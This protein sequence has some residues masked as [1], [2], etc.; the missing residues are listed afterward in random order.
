[1]KGGLFCKNVFMLVVGWFLVFLWTGW[2]PVNQITWLL[3]TA[4]VLPGMIA[5]LCSY[6]SFVFSTPTCVLVFP[7]AVMLLVGG[8]YTFGKVPGFGWL[9]HL[10]GT[11]RNPSDRVGH[12]LQGMIPAVMAQELL[13]R[14]TVIRPLLAACAGLC[15]AMTIS[16]GYN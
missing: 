13:L 8:H 4:H 9:A 5:L 6:R 7:G 1:M 3:E 11:R 15:A 14:K 12:V 16:A 10:L 2:A